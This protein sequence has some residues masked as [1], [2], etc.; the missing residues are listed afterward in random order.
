MISLIL[1]PQISMSVWIETVAVWMA[2]RTP[3]VH[4]SVPVLV[5]V[6]DSEQMEQ[7]VLVCIALLLL[8][9]SE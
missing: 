2:V 7:A 1:F 8:F 6:V 9:I 5:S 4:S 3:L